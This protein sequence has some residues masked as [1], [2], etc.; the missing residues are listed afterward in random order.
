MIKSKLEINKW[1]LKSKYNN[2]AKIA[3]NTDIYSLFLFFTT[4]NDCGLFSEF[5]SFNNLTTSSVN[6]PPI[7]KPRH[8]NS[9]FILSL[10]RDSNAI[11][12][13]DPTLESPANSSAVKSIGDISI[14]CLV[15]T[16]WVRIVV[17]DVTGSIFSALIFLSLLFELP[18]ILVSLVGIF[19]SLSLSSDIIELFSDIIGV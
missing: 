19:P 6:V 5:L 13:G 15:V 4:G 3:I 10:P 9:A 11:N 17:V 1:T 18:I 8:A 14:D 7:F 12:A 16:V 2:I